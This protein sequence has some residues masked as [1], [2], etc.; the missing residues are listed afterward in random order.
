MAEMR[1]TI[2]AAFDK[3]EEAEEEQ[4]GGTVALV[5]EPAEEPSEET[6]D[7]APKRTDNTPKD[8]DDD[9]AGDTEL[10]GGVDGEE[11][12]QSS[13]KKSGGD[14]ND[15]DTG[16][17]PVSWSPK[18]REAWKD[19]PEDVK[20]QVIKREKEVTEVLGR[21]TASREFQQNWTTVTQPYEGLMAAQGA[22]PIQA[23]K[24]LLEIGAALSLGSQA[25]KADVITKLIQQYQ[26]DINT[27]DSMLAGEGPA[28]NP[29][30]ERLIEQR[31]A[32]MQQTLA[33]AQ[34]EMRMREDEQQ[35]AVLQEIS[36][37]ASSKEAEFFEDVRAEMADLLE[38]SAKRGKTL[39][40]KEAYKQACS[41]NPEIKAILDQREKYKNSTKTK[42][43][44]LRKKTASSSVR[45]VT[46]GGGAIGDTAP[47][48]LS[49]TLRKAMASVETRSKRRV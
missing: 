10:S 15:G 11:E 13:E 17:A 41:L 1:E 29:E 48:S 24:R 2:E 47:E 22:T 6:K 36:D 45:G 49:D 19:M 26:I 37:F 18:A 23:V 21:T 30:V 7:E 3:H 16:R 12:Q 33:Q 28:T 14:S 43:E 38:M 8:E 4:A 27:L 32:P 42:E 5:E 20:A 39:G 35:R 46:S 25:Q 34:Y 44:L 31:L 40:M 9:S